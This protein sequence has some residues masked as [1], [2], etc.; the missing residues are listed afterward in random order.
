M[1]HHQT[2]RVR[3]AG[4]AFFKGF[5]I[6]Y[7]ATYVDNEPKTVTAIVKKQWKTVVAMDRTHPNFN[8]KFE[9]RS[10]DKFFKENFRAEINKHLYFRI[11]CSWKIATSTRK[12]VQVKI[13]YTNPP[14]KATMERDLIQINTAYF[15]LR[16]MYLNSIGTIMPKRSTKQLEKVLFPPTKFPDW[17]R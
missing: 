16:N 10:M 13:L 5:Q 15:N 3:F 1:K 11:E 9:A 14:E 17:A 8:K 4:S 6:Q 7:G 12:E 2:T